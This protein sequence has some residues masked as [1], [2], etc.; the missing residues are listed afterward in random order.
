MELNSIFGQLVPLYTQVGFWTT[1]GLTLLVWYAAAVGFAH[2]LFGAGR[3][4][5]VESA[6]KGMG[7]ALFLI[8]VGLACGMYFLFRPADVIY[9]AAITVTFLILAVLVSAVFS[10]MGKE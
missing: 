1:V 9:M 10:R 4:G 2:L 6:R 5:A 7:F 3:S 8:A